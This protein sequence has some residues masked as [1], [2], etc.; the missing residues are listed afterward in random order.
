MDLD[1]RG[2]KAVVSGASE[3]IGL[4]IARQL[5]AEGC[6][7]RIAARSEAKLEAAK[8]EIEAAHGVAVEVFALD[9]SSAGGQGEL[10]QACAGDTDILVNNAG[11]IPKG[12]IDE[13]DERT[14]RAAWDLKVFGYINL[15]RSFYA[16]M[17]A[18][19]S[20]VILNVIGNG[21]EKPVS[22]YI[23]GS[24]GNA[25]LMAFTR[26]LGGD[27][28][29]DGIRVV[30]IN[31]GPVATERLERMMRKT[32][33]DR[34]GDENRFAEFYKPFAFGRAGTSDEI[35]SMAAFLAS[36]L[37]AYTS[38]TIV[39]IDGGMVNKGPLF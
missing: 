13:I 14:W 36:D 16:G 1:L 3:G 39:T 29:Q 21:G 12:R 10:A 30:G 5:G 28:P 11:S 27:S 20:G 8:K 38:G 2:K 23:A 22:D 15:C 25:A 17:K 37:S 7:L 4:A 32:A 35:A 34:L 24:T 6:D 9:L 18:R 33:G 26:A 19:R 31:P